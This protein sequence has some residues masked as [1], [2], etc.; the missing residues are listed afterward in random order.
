MSDTFNEKE[1]KTSFNRYYDFYRMKRSP[2]NREDWNRFTLN[3]Q[4]I[5]TIQKQGKS[6]IGSDFNIKPYPYKFYFL[7]RIQWSFMNLWKWIKKTDPKIK[8]V[9]NSG[10]F[11]IIGAVSMFFFNRWLDNEQ[12]DKIK[13]YEQELKLKDQTIQNYEVFSDSLL[14]EIKKKESITKGGFE[15]VHQKDST[16]MNDND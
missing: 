3:K 11:I 8:N 15:L 2:K 5:D 10:T 14:I 1:L 16:L 9:I 13:K 12:Q 6:I 4:T 7:H